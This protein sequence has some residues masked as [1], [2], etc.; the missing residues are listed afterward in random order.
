VTDIH[1]PQMVSVIQHISDHEMKNGM[2]GTPVACDAS[3]HFS[4]FDKYLIDQRNNETIYE[5][6]STLKKATVATQK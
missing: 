2:T 3:H 6:E 1:F 5:T 4:I